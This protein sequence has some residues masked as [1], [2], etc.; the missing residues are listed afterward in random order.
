MQRVGEK[1]FSAVPPVPGVYIMT[2]RHEQVLYVGQSKNL[3][4]RLGSYKNSRPGRAPKK[5]I[6]LV[7][8]VENITWEKCASAEAA[9]LRENELLRLHR[10]KFNALNTWPKAYLFLWLRTDEHGLELGRTNSP[11]APQADTRLYGAFKTGAAAACGALLRSLWAALYQPHSPH[12]FPSRLLSP[13]PPLRYRL[14]WEPDATP[15]DAELLRLPLG[16]FLEGI[17]DRLLELLASVMPR[18]ELL[19]PFQRALQSNDLETLAQFYRFG[20]QRNF[21]LRR[22]YRL[23]DPLILQEQ[24]DDLLAQRISASERGRCATADVAL[25]TTVM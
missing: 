20:P 18:S 21:E 15:R 3:R 22:Q 12:D 13:R 11:D 1:F 24:L 4:A 16:D 25:R 19:S 6:R 10:P 7:Q 5:V 14:A 2:G 9:R 17:S 8:A 23:P